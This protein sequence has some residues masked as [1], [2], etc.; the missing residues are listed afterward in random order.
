M[1][2]MAPTGAFSDF[3]VYRTRAQGALIADVACLGGAC[4]PCQRVSK[5]NAFCAKG[6]RELLSLLKS[7]RVAAP[8]LI[9][10]GSTPLWNMV[11]KTKIWQHSRHGVQHHRYPLNGLMAEAGPHDGCRT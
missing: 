8:I 5:E 3:A 7:S 4:L 6:V 10:N 11:L 1:P 9:S 2:C